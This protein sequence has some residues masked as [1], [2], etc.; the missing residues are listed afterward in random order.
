[1]AY[2]AK[3]PARPR[4]FIIISDNDDSLKRV[5][6]GNIVNYDKAD[7]AIEAAAKGDMDIAFFV[8]FPDPTNARF[9]LIKDLGLTVVGVGSRAMSR[10]AVPAPDGGE[11]KRV[12]QVQN[13]PVQETYGGWGSDKTVSTMCT[14]IVIATA[15][16]EGLEGN[17]KMDQ[18]DLITVLNQAPEGAFEPQA[19]WFTG[20]KKYMAPVTDAAANGYLDAIEKAKEM[21]Q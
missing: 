16:P 20:V 18:E 2:P 14:E 9:K 1:L 15:S 17:P 8:Q 6:D 13:V 11:A 4:P 5:R 21:T 7:Q 10:L 19:S 12:F 3:K